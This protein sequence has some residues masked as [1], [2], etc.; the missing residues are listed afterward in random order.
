MKKST[1]L[2][3]VRT[4]R[5]LQDALRKLLKTKPYQKINIGEIVFKAEVARPT[6][7]LHFSSKDELLMS[8]FDDLFIDFRA[9]LAEEVKKTEL[10]Y[11]LIGKLMFSCAR[12]NAEGLRVLLNAGLDSLVEQRFRIIISET[13][14]SIRAAHPIADEA[15]VLTPYLDDFM[16]NGIF[17]L[18]ERWIQ[19]D[20]PIP[21]EIMGLIIANM[22][23]GVREML[24]DDN[25]KLTR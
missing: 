1:D 4:R 3:A 20:M 19:E 18:L 17:A 5:W 22:T 13:G 2:R 12:R 25:F 9:A 6:F 16:S 15:K 10:D 8:I 11:P 23:K 24:T 14:E 21:D 7:Y